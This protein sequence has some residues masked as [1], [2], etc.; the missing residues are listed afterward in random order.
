MVGTFVPWMGAWILA[1]LAARGRE[2]L[3]VAVALALAGTL[4]AGVVAVLVQ[5]PGAGW[6][7]PTFGVAAL[8]GLPLAVL[9]SSLGGRAA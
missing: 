5:F 4:G 6:N 7:V 1:N 8:A 2:S 3:G 9:A